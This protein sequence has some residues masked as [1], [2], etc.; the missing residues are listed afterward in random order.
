MKMDA[1]QF[2]ADAGDG[3]ALRG[4]ADVLLEYACADAMVGVGVPHDVGGSVLAFSH[5]HHVGLHCGGFG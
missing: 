3:V 5:H 4:L 1:A 2:V